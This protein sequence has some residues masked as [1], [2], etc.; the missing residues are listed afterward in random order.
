MTTFEEAYARLEHI[1]EKMN[2]GKVSLDESIK[3][4]EEAVELITTCQ[5]KLTEADKKIE[6]LI[7][8]KNGELA[9]D[10]LGK[11]LME[12]FVHSSLSR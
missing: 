5:N 1:L 8:A 9:V 2:S 6:I 3:L 10:E 11:P 7:K 4:Y 12:N